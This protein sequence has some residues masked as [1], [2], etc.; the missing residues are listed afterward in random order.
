MPL[1]PIPA[2]KT[3]KSLCSFFPHHYPMPPISRS[4]CKT[5]HCKMLLRD[6]EPSLWNCLGSSGRRLLKLSTHDISNKR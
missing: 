4:L 1:P 5:R 2:T 3:K 6:L